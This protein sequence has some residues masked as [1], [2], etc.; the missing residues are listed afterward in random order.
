M[1]PANTYSKPSPRLRR[2]KPAA[3]SPEQSVPKRRHPTCFQSALPVLGMNTSGFRRC[4]WCEMAPREPSML[5][6]PLDA[7]GQVVGD[8][9][10]AK[11][12]RRSTQSQRRSSR[13]LRSCAARPKRSKRRR[14]VRQDPRCS[15]LWTQRSNLPASEGSAWAS[16]VIHRGC[17][18]A[19]SSRCP[20]ISKRGMAPP[21]TPRTPKPMKKRKESGRWAPLSRCLCNTQLLL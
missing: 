18:L 16:R 11:G 1:S 21:C 9:C 8:S 14:L 10:S 13:E 5:M 20:P 2:A 7:T 3:L 17:A 15:S 19:Q 12:K 6:G 4:S